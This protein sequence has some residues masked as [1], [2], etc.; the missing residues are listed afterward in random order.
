MYS[1]SAPYLFWD[2]F[3]SLFLHDDIQWDHRS[4]QA[5][6]NQQMMCSLFFWF[7][8][9]WEMFFG[10]AQGTQLLS[11]SI[12]IPSW[13][14]LSP[15]FV[16]VF[17]NVLAVAAVLG[18]FCCFC[19]CSSSLVL[20]PTATRAFSLCT[21]SSLQLL[22]LC[23]LQFQTFLF[24]FTASSLQFFSHTPRVLRFFSAILLEC[25]GF[26]PLLESSVAVFFALLLKCCGF[27]LPYSSSVAVFFCLTPQV[28]RFFFPYS[29][30]VAV[31]FSLLLKCCVFFLPYSPSAAVSFS[32]PYCSSAAVFLKCCT[33]FCP[34]SKVLHFVWFLVAAVACSWQDFF[35]TFSDCFFGLMSKNRKNTTF[36]DMLCYGSRVARF[37]NSTVQTIWFRR[38][39]KFK[40]LYVGVSNYVD[41]FFIKQK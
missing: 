36:W 6:Y 28:L 19:S 38:W 7:L 25:C 39:G 23:S 13:N 34:S 12:R 30:S 8:V 24:I 16:L 17:G 33:W 32:Q 35:L 4:I 18:E 29:S 3:T 27:F 11:F 40:V 41:F 14:G 37:S 10:V 26:S 15:L 21:V 1:G 20:R 22:Q 2:T 31:F 9:V 5:A